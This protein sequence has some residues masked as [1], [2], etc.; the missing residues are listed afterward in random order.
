M[1]LLQLILITA[2]IAVFLW[3]ASLDTYY[4]EKPLRRAAKALGLGYLVYHSCSQKYFYS[5]TK[6]SANEWLASGIGDTI[7]FSNRTK[8]TLCIHFVK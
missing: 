3:I 2:A 5:V 1:F 4:L 8:E 7:L 6:K